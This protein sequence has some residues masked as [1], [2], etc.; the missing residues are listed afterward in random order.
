LQKSDRAGAGKSV[1][2]FAI[3]VTLGTDTT[4]TGEGVC[5]KEPRA[6]TAD[7]A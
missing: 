3:R 1:A 4:L 6:K 7:S 2:G 5:G